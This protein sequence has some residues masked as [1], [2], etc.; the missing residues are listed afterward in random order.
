MQFIISAIFFALPLAGGP[1]WEKIS[2][3]EGIV[4]ERRPH[5]GSVFYELRATARLNDPPATVFATVSNYRAFAEF[6]PYMKSLSVL[7]EEGDTAYVYE[8]IGMPLVADRDYTLKLNKRV[9][10]AG[11][12]YSLDFESADDAGPP[13]QKSLVRAQH[14][15]GSWTLQPG[16]GGKGT[17]LIYE[18]Y[19]EPGGSLPSFIVNA[20]QRSAPREVVLAMIRR[21]G[22]ERP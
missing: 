2:E 16:A 11:Q 17:L 14:I 13:P 5:A 21:A 10:A 9:D 19:S 18:F 1:A 15:R 3:K 20:A 8:R 4:V 22:G 6:I 12:V 7:R